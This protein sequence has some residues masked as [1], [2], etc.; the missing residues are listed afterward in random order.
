VYP[1]GVTLS[2]NLK[3]RLGGGGYGEVFEAELLA[4]Y[5]E[6]ETGRVCLSPLLLPVP[7]P[8]SRWRTSDSTT[9]STRVQY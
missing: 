6:L 7:D 5:Y 2:I 9:F 1:A 8:S 3:G 4:E